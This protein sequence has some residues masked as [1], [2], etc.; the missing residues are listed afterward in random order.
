VAVYVYMAV[1][2]FCILFNYVYSLHAHGVSSDFMTYMFLIPL[3]GGSL[4]F[5]WCYLLQNRVKAPSRLSFN[6]YNSGIAW[7]T[8]GSC[9]KGVIEIAGYESDYI[10]VFFVIGLFFL[11]F[12]LSA[13]MMQ[14]CG[15]K[16]LNQ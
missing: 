10:T 13:Y 2:A 7:L 16:P 12:G 1:A 3:L 6:L 11:F 15:K 5:A 4:V 14:Y 8:V 9:I